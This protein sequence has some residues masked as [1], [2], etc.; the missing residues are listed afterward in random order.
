MQLLR[1][2]TA[3]P[4]LAVRDI[5]C[6]FLLSL[7]FLLSL[8]MPACLGMPAALSL[9]LLSASRFL[10]TWGSKRSKRFVGVEC[11][12]QQTA[13]AVVLSMDVVEG[14]LRLF[15]LCTS[16]TTSTTTSGRWWNRGLRWC[17]LH[18]LLREYFCTF[19]STWV[20]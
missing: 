13:Q 15:C 9:A 17:I 5:F 20:V 19:S 16:T 7:T 1:Y 4:D 8:C 12:Q 6:L 11:I 3:R 2:V 18:L 14:L 10:V